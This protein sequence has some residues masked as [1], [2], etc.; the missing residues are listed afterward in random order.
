[1]RNLLRSILPFFL[2]LLSTAQAAET[3]GQIKGHVLDG[4]GIAVPGTQLSLSSSALL[5]DRSVETEADGRFRFPALPPGRYRLE[6]SKP[7][8][9]NWV[10]EDLRVELGG[11]ATVVVVLELAQAEEVITV[12]AGNPVVDVE[13]TRTGVTL[14]REFL[15]D[16]P[17]AARSYQGAVSVAPG[18]VG[19]GNANIHGGFDSSNQFY[20]DGVNT[21]DPLTNTFSLNMNYDAIEEIQVITGGMDAEYGR[22]LGGAVNIVTRSG[23]NEFEG[24]VTVFYSDESFQTEDLLPGEEPPSEFTD[25]TYAL[26]VGGPLIAD[27]LWF[28]VSGQMDIY[29]DSITFDNED[30]G[31]PEGNDPLTGEPMDVVAPRDWR[32]GYWFGKLTWQPNTAHRFSLHAQGDPA[33][34]VNVRQDAYV[35]PSAEAIQ[36]QGGWLTSLSHLWMISNDLNL[37]TQL[38]MQRTELDYYPKAWENPGCENYDAIGA[39]TDDFGDS[40]WFAAQAD[41]FSYGAF[42]YASF[43]ERNRSSANMALTWFVDD[44]LGEH[45]FKVGVQAE[46][47]DSAY[48][49]PGID[50]LEVWAHDGDPSNLEGYSPSTL[51]SYRMDEDADHPWDV[52]VAGTMLS[53]YVQDVWQPVPGLTLRPGVRMDRSL[54]QNNEELVFDNMTIA[55]RFGLAWDFLG[56]QSTNFHAFYGRFYD[57]GFLGISDLLVTIDQGVDIYY[58]DDKTEDWADEPAQSTYASFLRHDDLKNPYS[59]EWD[60]GLTR[61]LSDSTAVDFTWVHKDAH[62]F[63]EDDE[64]N[65]IWNEEGNE[66]IGSRNG[67]D[68]AIYRLRTA[69]DLYTKFDALEVSV[70]RQ[71]SE[72]W[73]LIGSYTWSKATGTNSDHIATG[74]FDNPAQRQYEQG[75]LSYDRT[76]AVKVLGSYRRPDAWRLGPARIG[77]LYGWDFRLYSGAPYRKL[78]YDNYN[79][80]WNNYG[81][82]STGDLRLPA[83]SQTNLRG[84]LSFEMNDVKLALT[85]DCYNVFNDR[86]V[87]SVDQTWG[88]E[89]GD[90]VYLNSDN[91]PLFGTILDRQRPRR[92]QVG[93]RGEF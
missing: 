4:G 44:L 68:E 5:G 55:P 66:V 16:L 89:A 27:K 79:A 63:W 52:S 11:A 13:R 70:N 36:T 10:A 30:I 21:T 90:G 43:N 71:W 17:T 58:W 67:Q 7:G 38:Y 54:L 47:L 39:C 92:F 48:V 49:Y 93:L 62:N 84:G 29:I 72:N 23:G 80:G 31:R 41:G 1:M 82:V 56:D 88:N 73:G 60:V 45:T 34:I 83:W 69:D 61:A 77:Y 81:D 53:A 57:S 22:S 20:V 14:D 85:A 26:N 87:T 46:R 64:V 35:L 32:S 65:L 42:P 33:K 15:R 74:A 51:Y 8:F 3:S 75:F 9:H 12:V 91:E 76:H 2:L 40:W 25:Q 19:S 78:Y 6:A 50:N 59:D 24:D 86:T 28:F 37:E 18:V